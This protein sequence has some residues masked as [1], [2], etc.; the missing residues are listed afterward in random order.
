M[1][2]RARGEHTKAHLEWAIGFLGEYDD[3]VPEFAVFLHESLF[4]Q[5][6]TMSGLAHDNDL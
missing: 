2:F 1:V 4:K 6:F 5:G 3:D